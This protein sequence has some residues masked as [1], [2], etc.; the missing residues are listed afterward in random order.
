MNNPIEIEKFFE[1]GEGENLEF[2][3]TFNNE[4]LGVTINSESVQNWINEIK[5]KTSPL[6]IPDVVVAESGNKKFV[7]FSIQ[8]YPIK[9]VATRGK[10]FKRI[11][12][13]N[14]M[15]S[16]SEVVNLHLQSF[17]TS[18][19]FHINNQFKINDIFIG[20]NKGNNN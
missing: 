3:S 6:L 4:V 1:M 5:N 15:L 7:I 17:N 19:D 12:N 13:S 18:W 11:V 16:V 8:E 14:H 2:K 20:S 9:P 10:Y